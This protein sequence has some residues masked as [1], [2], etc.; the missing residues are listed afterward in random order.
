[1]YDEYNEL[2]VEILLGKTLSEVQQNGD[3]EIIFRISGGETYKMYHEQSCC[4]RVTIEDITGNLDDLIGE[5]LLMAE[6]SSNR[7]DPKKSEYGSY[8]ESCTWTFYRF[9][10]IK[11]SVTIRWYGAS[12]GCYGEQVDFVQIS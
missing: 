1:M 9:A 5:P 4:E 6:E 11:G 8:D 3:D 2:G 12:N 7:E 10:T